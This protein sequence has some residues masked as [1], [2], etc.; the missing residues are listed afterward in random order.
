M[1]LLNPPDPVR[2]NQMKLRLLDRYFEWVAVAPKAHRY[3]TSTQGHLCL[4]HVFKEAYDK[5]KALE[6]ALTPPMLFVPEL[7][8]PRRPEYPALAIGDEED[9]AP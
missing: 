8:R 2:I 1:K 5:L 6:L 9:H 4:Y 3:K 7:P